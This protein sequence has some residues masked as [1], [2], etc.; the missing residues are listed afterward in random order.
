LE[1]VLNS[2]LILAA[3]GLAVIFFFRELLR[4]IQKPRVTQILIDPQRFFD[5]KI[6]PT[7]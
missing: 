5:L 6:C 7:E 2:Y 4:R 1:A 3:G